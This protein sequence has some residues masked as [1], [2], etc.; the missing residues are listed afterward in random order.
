MHSPDENQLWCPGQSL[1]SLITEH[2]SEAEL[3]KIHAALGDPLVDMYTEVH[4]EAEMWYKKWQEFRCYGSHHSSSE[5][6]FTRQQGFP[7]SDPPAVKELVRAEVKMLLETL[8]ERA[9]KDERDRE[10]LLLRYKPET[11]NYV[12]GHQGFGYHR[13][14]NLRN[15][16]NFNSR[17][18]SCCSVMS[19]A[20]GEIESVKDKLNVT[21][22]HRV[23]T[24]IRCVLLKEC[25]AL[26]KMT[27]H[28]KENIKQKCMSQ[29]DSNKPEPSLTELKE[30]RAAIQ[31]DLKLL[32]SSPGASSSAPVWRPKKSCRFPAEPSS[33]T[34]L[35]P[36]PKSIFRLD[37]PPLWQL[38]PRPPLHDPPTRTSSVR[39]L[40]LHRST[41]A[42][43]ESAKPSSSTRMD[44]D[45]KLTKSREHSSFSAEP[46]FT[47]LPCRT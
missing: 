1:W 38:K 16:D 22:I 42:S 13:S 36:T 6:Y 21:E 12:L 34:C 35:A 8:R 14:P 27:K 46:D 17:P 43:N 5:T 20:K 23:I 40:G 9:C 41:L 47:G 32:P 30:L 44:S 19:S 18:S 33:D 24:Q 4:S 28:F 29:C 7:L 25:E 10:E 37:L 11:L 45:L 2:V 3:L 15:A 26:T 31:T 39:T